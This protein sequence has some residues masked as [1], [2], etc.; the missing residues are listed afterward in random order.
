M[1]NKEKYAK[2]IVELACD[3]NRIA[4]VRQTGEF[5]SCYEMPCRECLFHS[6]AKRCKEKNKRVG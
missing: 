4:I 1:K 3:G 2:E 5:R 6:N